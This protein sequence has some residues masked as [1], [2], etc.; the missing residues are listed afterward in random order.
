MKISVVIPAYF[1]KDNIG[2]LTKRLL[3]EVEKIYKDFN[4]LYIIQGDD[5][6]KEILSNFDDP[7][8]NFLYF[9]K[10]LGVAKAFITGFKEVVLKS[11]YIITMDS[12]L[13][14]QPEEIKGLWNKM[15]ET[16]ADIVIGSRFIKGGKIIGMPLWKNIA[17][18]TMNKM[19][20]IFSGISV[21]DKTSGFRIYKPKV[22]QCVLDNLKAE[23]F[24]FYPEVILIANKFGF[25]FAEAPITFKFR[26]KG[27][28]KM[29]KWQTI[30]G[31][32]K[33]FSNKIIK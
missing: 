9:Q 6:S 25:K 27:E 26:V 4:I 11:D 16:H 33:M 29:Y 14:H 31:Y 23:N 10:P 5:G 1:E 19:I 22:I 13:N 12:D 24:E 28:S 3:I 18:R 2:E 7:R 15:L 30:K 17:S 20:N 32:L 8:V 21:A